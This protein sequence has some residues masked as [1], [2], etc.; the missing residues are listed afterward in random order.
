[1]AKTLLNMKKIDYIS[2]KEQ[3]RH[4]RRRQLDNPVSKVILYLMMI[5]PVPSL[6]VAGILTPEKQKSSCR[7]KGS[8]FK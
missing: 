5:L 7:A 3:V 8:S 1:M 6:V 2:I 4:R